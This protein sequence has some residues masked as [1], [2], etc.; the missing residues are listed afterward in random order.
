MIN[1]EQSTWVK[2]H[3]SIASWQWYNDL[4]TK[5]VFLHLLIKANHE[6]THYRGVIVKRGE[7]L[8]GRKQLAREL[9]LSEQEIRTAINHLLSSEITIKTTSKYSVITVLNY[10]NYQ[11]SQPT[12]K[13]TKQ[14]TS[15][16]QATKNQP[17]DNHIQELKELKELKE[18]ESLYDAYPKK[19]DKGHA[20][21]AIKKAIEKVGAQV[22][23]DAVKRYAS[24]WDGKDKQFCPNPASWFN[25]ER[26][27]D[28]TLRVQPQVQPVKRRLF[29]PL[30]MTKEIPD[31]N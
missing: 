25:G 28:E 15:N 19:V 17:T 2:L 12:K 16:Q 24:Q 31:G 30:E 29:V 4:K 1:S 18:I 26:W 8:T 9:E 23:L 21:K 13:P 6:E 27:E 22:L 11:S 3:R 20:L 7:V 5:S 10:D 14:P